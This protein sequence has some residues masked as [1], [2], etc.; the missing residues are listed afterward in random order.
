M[1]GTEAWNDEIASTT[2]QAFVAKLHDHLTQYSPLYGI[3]FEGN[4]PDGKP[5]AKRKMKRQVGGAIIKIPVRY[6]FMSNF[7][8]V[9]ESEVNQPQKQVGIGHAT[10]TWRYLK[11]DTVVTW[12]D[13]QQN[14]GKHQVV[15]LLEE[16]RQDIYD[17]ARESIEDMLLGDGTAN[18]N[19]DILGLGAL[20]RHTPTSGTLYGISQATAMDAVD[21]GSN[22]F[23]NQ[24]KT[25]YSASFLSGV[26]GIKDMRAMYN[27]CRYTSRGTGGRLDSPDYI[28]NATAPY[29]SYEQLAY[30]LRRIAEIEMADLGFQA[31]RFKDSAMLL[32]PGLDD[33][34]KSDGNT[35]HIRK[36]LNTRYVYPC[37][38]P[39]FF[40][41]FS[42]FRAVNTGQHM[43]YVAHTVL[44][45]QLC[46]ENPSK[47]GYLEYTDATG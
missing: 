36:F 33:D 31:L 22:Y 9:G 3:F 20:I 15:N 28:L 14:A 38:D 12:Q 24:Y 25:S 4:R 40:W 11:G 23:R 19:K 1:A 16:K 30:E 27:L 10:A 2:M 17:H 45:G 18:N 34:V 42:P 13:R 35:G 5:L 41:G 26:Q 44:V 37:I 21:S 29:E 7:R 39:T 46:C 43:D 32:V 6:R 8:S 47:L